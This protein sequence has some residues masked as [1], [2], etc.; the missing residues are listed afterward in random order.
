MEAPLLALPAAKTDTACAVTPWR[1]WILITY[2]F[3]SSM[4][5]LTW[6]LPGTIPDTMRVVYAMSNDTLHLLLCVLFHVFHS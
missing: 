6:T 3:L 2:T 1:W 5:A 4:Q